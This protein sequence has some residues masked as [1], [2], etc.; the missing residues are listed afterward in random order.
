MT[1]IIHAAVTIG[2]NALTVRRLPPQR[3]LSKKMILNQRTK[4]EAKFGKKTIRKIIKKGKA[5]KVMNRN[6]KRKSK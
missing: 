5:I 6:K 2:F 3:N 1:L 4:S